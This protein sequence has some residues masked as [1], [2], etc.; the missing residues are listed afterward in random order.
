MR[1]A[2]QASRWKARAEQMR[3]T[4]KEQSAEHD[5]AL[6]QMRQQLE[7][8]TSEAHDVRAATGSADDGNQ[9]AMIDTLQEEIASLHQ[10]HGAMEK[11]SAALAE[12]LEAAKA[13]MA[14]HQAAAESGGDAAAELAAVQEELSS[15]RAAHGEAQ[16]ASAVLAEQLEAAEAAKATEV[17]SWKQRAEKMRDAAKE[18]VE[19]LKEAKKQLASMEAQ[20]AASAASPADDSNSTDDHA[21]LL[22]QNVRLLASVKTLESELLHARGQSAIGMSGDSPM[23][24]ANDGQIASAWSRVIQHRQ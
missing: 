1:A 11:E 19:K 14:A 10:T 7:A 15:V 18:K 13:E 6:E 4:S 12:Q 9:S 5:R 8:R 16:S 21:A 23:Q 20:L 22:A 24:I 3:E 2:R 17:G